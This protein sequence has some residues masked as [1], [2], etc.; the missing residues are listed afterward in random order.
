MR[1]GIL[2]TRVQNAEKLGGTRQTAVAEHS[3]AGVNATPPATVALI[4][5]RV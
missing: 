2:T 4:C 5:D 3:R 1:A